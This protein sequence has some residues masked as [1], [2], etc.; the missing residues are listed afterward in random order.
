MRYD[1]FALENM[2]VPTYTNLKEEVDELRKC[3]DA[4]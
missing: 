1:Q 4:N 2:H 3:V